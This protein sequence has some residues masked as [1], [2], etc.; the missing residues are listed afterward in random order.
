MNDKA[1]L[2]ANGSTPG[3][4]EMLRWDWGKDLIET[5]DGDDWR[6]KRRDGLG[7]WIEATNPDGLDLAIK[8][9]CAVRSVPR[10]AGAQR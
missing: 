7:G 10:D 3:A 6:A 5:D 4:L 2:L 9:D 8:E 1:G